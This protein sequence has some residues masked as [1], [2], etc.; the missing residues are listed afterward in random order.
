[1]LPKSKVQKVLQITKKYNNTV[2]KHLTIKRSSSFITDNAQK[3]R[4]KR[5][6]DT[7]HCLGHQIAYSETFVED[8][9]AEWSQY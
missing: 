2:A 1:M 3:N 7:L 4:I 9:C 6:L 5:C 8:K